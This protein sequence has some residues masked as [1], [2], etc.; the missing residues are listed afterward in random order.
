[1]RLTA[2]LLGV[3]G[4]ALAAQASANVTFYEREGFR[5]RVFSVEGEVD[6][7]ARTGFNDAAS[8]VVVDRGRWEVC[9]HARFEGRCV[10]LRPGSYDSLRSMGLNN[11]ISSVRPVGRYSRS[12][13]EAPPAMAAPNYQ[14]RAR[15]DERL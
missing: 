13:Y 10:L 2:K 8:S 7:F 6:N 12:D 15:P 9:E 3:A 1:M 4:I 11:Q 14:W 5:G